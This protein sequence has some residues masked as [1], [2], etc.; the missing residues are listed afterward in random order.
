MIK[1]RLETARWYYYEIS[2]FYMAEIIK[3]NTEINN[4][5]MSRDPIILSPL[6]NTLWL[7]Y[8]KDLNKARNCYKYIT[9]TFPKFS[10]KKIFFYSLKLEKLKIQ[11]F[12][13]N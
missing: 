5:L 7:I 6:Y 1:F 4:Q 13:W 2:V 8:K 10:I 12:M 11:M 3:L 9:T